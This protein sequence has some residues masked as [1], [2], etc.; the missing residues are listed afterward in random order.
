[1]TKNK[2]RLKINCNYFWQCNWASA[3]K[4]NALKTEHILVTSLYRKVSPK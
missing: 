3:E 2:T 4:A 1:M